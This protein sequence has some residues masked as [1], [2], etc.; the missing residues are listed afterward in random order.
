[1]INKFL[2]YKAIL[3]L[4]FMNTF[5]IS[6][7]LQVGFRYE[8]GILFG[9]QESKNLNIPLI[10]SLSGNLLIEPVELLNIELHPGVVLID[11]EYSGFE[12]GVFGKIKIP[13]T[14]FHFLFGVNNHY[15]IGTAHNKGGSYEK[16]MFYKGFGMGYNIGL[17]SSIDLTYFWTSDKKYAYAIES[18]DL[19]YSRIIYKEVKGLLRL[20]FNITWDL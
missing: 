20:G 5:S 17:N 16:G 12:F 14:Q 8:P 19:T 3:F 10:F 9:K 1:M 18:D 2:I 11:D 4:L 7:S 13:S 15:N 6:Q